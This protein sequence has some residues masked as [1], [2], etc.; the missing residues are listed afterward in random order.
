M[1]YLEIKR[2]KAMGVST[3]GM[4]L[5]HMATQQFQNVF[6][7]RSWFLIGATTYFQKQAKR[8]YAAETEDRSKDDIK[9]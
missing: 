9:W 2:V 7:P 8:N 1:D 3:G 4:T 5:L 6:K